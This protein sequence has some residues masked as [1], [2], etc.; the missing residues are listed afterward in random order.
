MG[1]SDNLD[2]AVVSASRRTGVAFGGELASELPAGTSR[3]G[4]G[5]EVAVVR[6]L[7]C[8]QTASLVRQI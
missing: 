8:G 1:A 4:F 2:P 6:R 7:V 3:Y 5:V